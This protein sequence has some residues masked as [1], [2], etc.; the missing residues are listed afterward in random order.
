MSQ[1][2]TTSDGGEQSGFGIRAST[3]TCVPLGNGG[4][5]SKHGALTGEKQLGV[6]ATAGMRRGGSMAVLGSPEQWV[7][8][9]VQNEEPIHKKG[10]A[11]GR[12]GHR[13]GR[14]CSRV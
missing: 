13:Q 7:L 14:G 6:S 11:Q 2:D 4:G 12:L 1:R 10:L 3:C 8:A 5:T 9:Q